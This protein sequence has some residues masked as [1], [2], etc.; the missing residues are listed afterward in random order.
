MKMTAMTQLTPYEE[1]QVHEIAGWKA[2]PPALAIE[3][4]DA[5]AHPLVKLAERFVPQ[6][7]VRD[8]ITIAYQNSEILAHQSDVVKY[9]QVANIHELK[10]G[11]LA[12]C[13]RLAKHFALTASRNAVVRGAAMKSGPVL[14]AELSMMYALKAVHTIGYCY[15]FGLH[16]AR[17]RQ[18]A[19]QTLLVASAA[20]MQ[21]KQQAIVNLRA[22]EDE[23]VEEILEDFI[24]EQFDA[25]VQQAV[26]EAAGNSIPMI[27]LAVGG[28]TNGAVTYHTALVATR[29]FQERWLR[30]NGKIRTIAPDPRFAR[31]RLQRAGRVISAC[32]YW[33]SYAVAF[34]ATYPTVLLS[35]FLPSQ[36]AAVQGLIDGGAAASADVRQLR[37]GVREAL[38]VRGQVVAPPA[39]L[40]APAPA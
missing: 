34:A 3:A 20:S 27:G 31:S 39:V 2:E 5:L 10:R 7:A 11:D 29:V 17:E 23:L 30:A 18:Y 37:E 26:E 13:D 25:I 14:S 1:R 16:V 12:K 19:L 21:A 8:A 38:T 15:G 24:E 22:L 32:V 35:S 6:Q 33:P 9:A 28:L 4:M 36:N 40:P